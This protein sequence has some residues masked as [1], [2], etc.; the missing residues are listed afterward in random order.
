MRL[1]TADFRCCRALRYLGPVLGLILLP[2]ALDLTVLNSRYRFRRFCEW[3]KAKEEADPVDFVAVRGVYCWPTGP[4]SWFLLLPHWRRLAAAE[5][6]TV[7][8]VILAAIHV[9]SIAE[10]LLAPLFLWDEKEEL[11][12]EAEAVRIRFHSVQKNVV[13][14]TSSWFVFLLTAALFCW[15]LWIV[16]AEVCM[17]MTGLLGFI[18]DILFVWW[19]H[20]A[21]QRPTMG[22]NEDQEANPPMSLG[23]S[24]LAVLAI[25][26]LGGGFAGVRTGCNA[27]SRS[28]LRLA[29]R[30]LLTRRPPP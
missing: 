6:N 9:F 28:C 23:N 11:L 13:E 7:Q 30:S 20:A 16:P 15:F 14:V 3:I 21:L 1:I 29:A 2:F 22:E 17:F 12:A 8:Q 27:V 25:A 18:C 4:F 19:L 10:G 24:L 5:P 26:A